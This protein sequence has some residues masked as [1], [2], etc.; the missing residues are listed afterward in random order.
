MTKLRN[1]VQ[2]MGRL[3]I[4]PKIITFGDDK[5]V[6][7]YSLAT[8]DFFRDKNGEKREETQWHNIVT[9]GKLAE[10]SEKYLSKGK[11]VVLS[12]KIVYRKWESDD[13]KEHYIT[14]IVADELQMVSQK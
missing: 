1:N 2:L 12:G 3:G 10:I 8:K 7:K 13:G 9:F 14:E 4:D 5:K 6:A 11:E